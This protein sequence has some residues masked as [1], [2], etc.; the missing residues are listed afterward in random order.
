MRVGVP[1]P[2]DG[3]DLIS[4]TLEELERRMREG[5]FYVQTYF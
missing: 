4:P 2:P 3:W 1:P 5:S